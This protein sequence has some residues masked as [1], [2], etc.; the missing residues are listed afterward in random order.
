MPMRKFWNFTTQASGAGA[1]TLYGE[2]S[3]ATWFGDEV[4]PA[5]FLKDL[6]AL[7]EI[8]T[9]DVYINSPGGD[10][11]AGYAI[12]H[13]LR[14]HPARVTVHVD[15]LAASAA[16]VV[17]MAGDRIVMPEASMMMVHRA[18]TLACGD[19]ARLLDIA[20]ELERVDG[21][22]A[23]IYAARTGKAI[24]E[25]KDLMEAE[26]WMTGPEALDLG[27]CDAVEPN[28]RIA[29]LCGPEALARYKHPPELPGDGG[30]SQPVKDKTPDAGE[31]LAAQQRRFS[32]RQKILEE[33]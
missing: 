29:A 32:L 33:K 17:A 16:S 19:A 1:L 4:T 25:I 28:K 5:A 9:L 14:R 26:T 20:A 12:Y 18:W 23:Q 2:I 30:E 11:F 21:Q 27:F 8:R 10:V 22:L 31:R 24:E 7:G 6:E 15:G 13:M 3:D